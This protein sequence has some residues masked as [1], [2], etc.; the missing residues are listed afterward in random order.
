MIP[1]TAL[2]SAR[3]RGRPGEGVHGAGHGRQPGD[4]S[5]GASLAAQRAPV[6]ASDRAPFTVT[7]SERR[8]CRPLSVTVGVSLMPRSLIRLL[9]G[10]RSE[11]HT[12]ELQSLR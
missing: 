6:I 1:P 3:I 4:G 5:A 9:S 11:E 8:T 12:S 7:R 2:W 10:T